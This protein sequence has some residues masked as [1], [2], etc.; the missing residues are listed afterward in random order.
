MEEQDIKASRT[1]AKI[2][3]L[4]LSSTSNDEPS[5]TVGAISPNTSNTSAATGKCF[6]CGGEGH[7]ANACPK[8]TCNHSRGAPRNSFATFGPK[9]YPSQRGNY[10]SR[11]NSRYPGRQT[12]SFHRGQHFRQ[13]YPSRRLYC[14]Y[15]DTYTH[16]TDECAA[17]RQINYHR[18]PY[19]RNRGGHRQ[20]N[21]SSPGE[22]PR[23]ASNPPG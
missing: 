13:S 9:T 20:Q 3:S 15:H 6:T 23:T 1:I 2:G 17:L 18:P 8:V 4:S 10:H 11:I 16:N 14:S 22:V 7:F 21:T 5:C 19:N 12:R